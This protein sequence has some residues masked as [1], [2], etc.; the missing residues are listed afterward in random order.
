M[1]CS[2]MYLRALYYS[3]LLNSL[4]PRQA[5]VASLLDFAAG[6]GISRVL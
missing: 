4:A 5:L 6:A 3:D 1:A 2:P